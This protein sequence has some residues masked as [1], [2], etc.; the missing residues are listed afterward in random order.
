MTIKDHWQEIRDVFEAAGQSSLH[1]AV[2]TVDVD[3]YPYVTPIGSL[4]LGD[5]CTGYYFE[6]LPVQLK[7]NLEKTGRVTVLAQNS[8]PTYWLE[9]LSSGQFKTYPGM[10]LMGAALGVREATEEEI[11]AWQEKVRFAEGLKG[12]NILWK[13]MKTVRDIRFDDFKPVLCGEMT[14]HLGK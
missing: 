7:E 11:F 5:D 1:F 6:S 4:I 8:D 13:D 2:A 10:R 14:A 9:S 3:G 12:H